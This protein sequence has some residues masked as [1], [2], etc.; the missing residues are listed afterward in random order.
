[1]TDRKRH[2]PEDIAEG[3]IKRLKP[4]EKQRDD[5][6]EG[7]PVDN[8]NKHV[9]ATTPSSNSDIALT[10]AASFSHI[11]YFKVEESEIGHT[12]L[13]AD[14]KRDA[15]SDI[16]SPNVKQAVEERA[17]DETQGVEKEEANEKQAVE[18]GI[19]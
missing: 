8:F 17:A 10:K 16:L 13:T 1:M 12:I 9:V 14:A 4:D 11:S 2:V 5:N 18:K 19:A 3:Q 15:D 6:E 7:Q